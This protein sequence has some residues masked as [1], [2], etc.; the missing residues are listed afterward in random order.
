VWIQTVDFGFLGAQAGLGRGLDVAVSVS[1]VPRNGALSLAPAVEVG[2]ATRLA[3]FD[4]RVSTGLV[5]LLT[6][7]GD[8]AASLGFDAGGLGGG[9]AVQRG[10][11]D[12]RIAVNLRGFWS[13]V[14]EGGGLNA[15]ADALLRL[16]PHWAAL[17]G[18]SETAV[19]TPEATLN[20]VTLGPGGRFLF[21]PFSADFSLHVAA[22]G[23]AG[24]CDDPADCSDNLVV[25]FPLIALRYGLGGN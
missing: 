3:D 6:F 7:P 20:A 16:G 1:G 19:W 2:W 18:I 17:A 21:G 15:T 11:V 14:A 8:P 24:D 10:T 13:P 9:V 25:P 4:V 12:R 5:S 23:A 22:A